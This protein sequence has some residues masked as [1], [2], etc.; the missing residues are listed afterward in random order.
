MDFML[1]YV[2]FVLFRKYLE[3][4]DVWAQLTTYLMLDC[5]YVR[6]CY[7]ILSYH[8]SIHILH[9]P[10]K[11]NFSA[12]KHFFGRTGTGNPAHCRLDST[13]TSNGPGS[14]A[15]LMITIRCGASIGKRCA[16][17]STGCKMC[18][19]KACSIDACKGL[20]L[21]SVLTSVYRLYKLYQTIKSTL[22]HLDRRAKEQRQDPTTRLHV[23]VES[24]HQRAHQ[25]SLHST[26]QRFVR[27]SSG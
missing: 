12:R 20:E 11:K 27:R 21:R 9:L 5:R 22:R 18:D 16:M 7:M 26:M 13:S 10:P 24:I 14:R 3:A 2:K 23:Q 25:H 4:C 6:Y 8:I 19:L 17:S 1:R 15:M